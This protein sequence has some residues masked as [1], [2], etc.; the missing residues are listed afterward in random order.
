MK[1]CRNP[2]WQNLY[3]RKHRKQALK[4]LKVYAGSLQFKLKKKL[5]LKVRTELEYPSRE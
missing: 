2:Q 3:I 4:K 5:Q 1:N